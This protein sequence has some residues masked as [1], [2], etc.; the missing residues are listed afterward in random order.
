MAKNIKSKLLILLLLVFSFRLNSHAFLGVGIYGGLRGSF[1]INTL[2]NIVSDKKTESIKK[3]N[4][5]LFLSLNAGLEFFDIRTEIELAIRNIVPIA[6]NQDLKTQYSNLN[7]AMFNIYYNVFS[8]Y[9]VKFYINGGIGFNFQ[10]PSKI[11]F[12]K[13]FN[14][15]V[16]TGVNF[17]LLLA[18]IDIGYRYINIGAIKYDNI[19]KSKPEAHQIYIG[20]RLGI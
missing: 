20:V 1:P 7:N 16:G 2:Q 9:I 14:W 12:D 17:N 15:S 5:N 8:I 10:S 6:T 19:I 3:L 18:N 4:S 11:E 13:N